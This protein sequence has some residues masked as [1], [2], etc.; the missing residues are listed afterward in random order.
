MWA[1]AYEW[2]CSVASVTW[3]LQSTGTAYTD[4]DQYTARESVLNVLGYPD[5]VNETYGA[6]SSACLQNGL[7]QYGLESEQ[8]WVTFDQAYAI[9]SGTTGLINPTGMYHYMAIR[10]VSGDS[11]WVANS[12]EGYCGIYS[13]LSRSQFNAFG[14]VQVVAIR[15]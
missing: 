5:C 12:A 13:T 15:P 6:M 3:V 1:Q 7:S 4:V 8:A 9:C 14:P 10:G 11:L 2:T